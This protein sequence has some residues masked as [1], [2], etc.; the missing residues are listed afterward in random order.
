MSLL[1]KIAQ[2]AEKRWWQI[3]LKNKDVHA[4]TSW[5]LSYW[6]NL[7]QNISDYLPLHAQATILDVGC[8]PAG[9]FMV[10]S[11]HYVTAL[12]PLIDVY[13]KD[14]RHFKKT[15]YPHVTFKVAGIEHVGD[16][17]Q[18]DVIFC[19]NAIN[20]VSDI[21]KGYENLSRLLK[22]NGK[23]VISVDA[24]NYKFF[25]YLFRVLPGDILHPCQYD[26]TEY[27]GF[28]T[29]NNLSVFKTEKLKSSFFFDYYL[30]VVE[31]A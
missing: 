28:L 12:D 1:W 6:K 30:Q 10:L 17:K 19:M 25:K 5:K 22:P 27:T 8:G 21:K 24:H 7:L 13:E 2:K 29:D 4:Y 23:L 26:L 11:G 31:K 9:I 18:Y 16:D 20:H 15:N 14:L 3:Y